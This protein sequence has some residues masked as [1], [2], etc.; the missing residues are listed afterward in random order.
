N[1][2]WAARSYVARAGAERG[3]HRGRHLVPAVGFLAQS[4][5]PC[6]RELVETGAPVVVG[7]APF[8]V[9]QPAMFEAIE[10]RIERALLDG[11]RVAGDLL[12]AEQDAVAVQRPERGR[13]QDEQIERPAE[14]RGWLH[15]SPKTYRGAGR[16][17]EN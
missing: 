7:H 3:G 9:E 2:S 6:R 8:A 15:C 12:D 4:T 13:L 1:G 16:F 10:R 17:R 14:Q 11:E 5:A